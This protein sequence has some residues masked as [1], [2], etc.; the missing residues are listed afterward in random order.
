MDIAYGCFSQIFTSHPVTELRVVY[1][2]NGMDNYTQSGAE[3]K[4][5]GFYAIGFRH[6]LGG[7]ITMAGG[8]GRSTLGNTVGDLGVIFNF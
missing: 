2:D 4:Q 3:V 5:E 6:G 8:I 7:G 1:S